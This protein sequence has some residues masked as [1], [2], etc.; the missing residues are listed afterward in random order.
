MQGLVDLGIV[1]YLSTG[2]GQA[3]FRDGAAAHDPGL[4][5]QVEAAGNL[6]V[7]NHFP[8]AATGCAKR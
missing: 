1:D 5:D 7:A 2:S 4:C 6:A 3:P 8:S